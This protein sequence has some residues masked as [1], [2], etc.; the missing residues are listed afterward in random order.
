[1]HHDI[2]SKLCLKPK[3]MHVVKAIKLTSRVCDCEVWLDGN[4]VRLQVTMEGTS[5]VQSWV[6]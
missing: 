5:G 1:M 6:C 3:A 4:T 2:K